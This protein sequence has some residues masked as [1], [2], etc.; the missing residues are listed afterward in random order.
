MN[1]VN[2]SKSLQEA[3]PLPFNVAEQLHG[4]LKHETISL[5]CEV[6]ASPTL[7]TF[8][9]TFNSS[10]DLSEISPTKFTNDGT[11]SRLNYTPATD[12]DYGTVGCWANNEI[13][14]SKQPCVY[15]I[16]AAGIFF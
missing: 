6:E 11:I 15:Q 16:I 1:F 13:G 2:A 8:R 4:A 10:G 3:T 9:W 7:V 12:M 5:A 14:Q